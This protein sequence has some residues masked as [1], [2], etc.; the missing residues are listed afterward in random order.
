[1]VSSEL[2]SL[3]SDGTDVSKRSTSFIFSILLHGAVIGV[4]VYVALFG[5]RVRHKAVAERL[6]VRHLDLNMPDPVKAVQGASGNMYPA[7]HKAPAGRPGADQAELHQKIDAP[8]GLETLMQS[9]TALTLPKDVPIPTVVLL[10]PEKE[11]VKTIV[12]P[13]PEAIAAAE[14]KPTL[15]LPNKE[16]QLADVPMPASELTVTKVPIVA[17]TT[18]PVVVH[19]PDLP[20]KPPQTTSNTNAQPTP[21]TVVALSDI[22]MKQGTVV[23][24][25]SNMSGPT[26]SPG[27][28]TQGQGKAVNPAEVAHHDTEGRGGTTNAEGA[29]NMKGQQEQAGPGSQTGAGN[30]AGHGNQPP[31]AHIV[32]PKTGAFGSVVVGASMTDRYPEASGAWK[33]RLAYTV[34]LHVGLTKS[35]IMQYSL[36]RDAEAAAAGSVLKLEPPWP[37]NIVRPAAG[38]GEMNADAM[39][40]HGFVNEAGRFEELNIVFPPDYDQTQQML[41]ALQQ[42]VFRPAT[43]NGKTARVEVLLVIPE[44]EQ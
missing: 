2:I 8:P 42:W 15:N 4:I 17:S 22:Q 34:Y 43:Q 3:F 26:S 35:W 20:Q 11:R 28:L 41:G 27:A 30:G 14:A 32:L 24:P 25:S 19:G 5:P 7:A 44:E 6:A 12:P 29:G 18:T 37:Y 10:T 36:P 9:K 23:L 21:A 16:V 1:M 40:V 39:M 31:M 38:P 13:K 33:G